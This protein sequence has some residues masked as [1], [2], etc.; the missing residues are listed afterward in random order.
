MKIHNSTEFVVSLQKEDTVL[1]LGLG[2]TKEVDGQEAKGLWTA[3]FFTGTSPRIETSVNVEK[4]RHGGRHS[5]TLNIDRTTHYWAITSFECDGMSDIRL[6]LK[7]TDAISILL[8]GI[9]VRSIEAVEAGRCITKETFL[10]KKQLDAIKGLV[11][12]KIILSFLI[13]LL[14]LAFAI[15]SALGVFGLFG[16]ETLYVP[17]AFV[18]TA[19]VGFVFF[20]HVKS[21]LKIKSWSTGA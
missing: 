6:V 3:R 2:E 11:L 4:H 18:F 13:F 12:S 8:P 15:E 17:M 21:F 14:L 10:S 1:E 19:V 16:P 7:N 9:R 20:V 5:A